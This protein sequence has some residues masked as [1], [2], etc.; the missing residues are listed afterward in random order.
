MNV[1]THAQ[2]GG[3]NPLQLKATLVKF[4]RVMFESG[5]WQQKENWRIMSETTDQI[6][7]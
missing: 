1:N 5:V 6:G 7:F 2:R 4:S 3:A